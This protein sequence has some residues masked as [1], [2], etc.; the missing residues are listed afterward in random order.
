ML[1]KLLASLA[2]L[3][4][5]SL[6]ALLLYRLATG[7]R[8]TQKNHLLLV[9]FSVIL[10]HA[11]LL[12]LRLFS[13]SG[14]ELSFF[15]VFSLITWVVT[16]MI[17]LAAWREP[18]ENLAIGVFPLAA[19]AL[20]L[21]LSSDKVHHLSTSLSMGLEVH[22]VTS[23]VAYALLSL[24]ALQAILLY[25]QDSHL[26][27]KHPAGFVRALPPLE[28]MEQL[29]FRMIA[30]GFIILCI[31]LG[32][33]LF[34]IEDLIS[35]HKTV[36]SLGAWIFFAILLFGRW[37]FGWRGRTAIR[38]TLTGFAFLLLAYFGSK[39]VLELILQRG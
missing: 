25:V 17:M 11:Y 21:R 7:G 15:T 37:K 16:T 22:I 6:T 23:I 36:L 5:L 33:G 9:S 24:A 38:W 1:E 13:G 10:I 32:T 34:Y 30:I 2:I 4:Y 39:F 18:V 20:V 28:T 31:S 27:N 29:L 26:R 35:Q 12:Y 19:L 8:G 14:L 3:I